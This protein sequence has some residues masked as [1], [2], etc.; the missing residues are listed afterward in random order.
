[1][2]SILDI[3]PSSLMD[4][5]AAQRM[6]IQ[7]TL[8]LRQSMLD[9]FGNYP[10]SNVRPFIYALERSNAQSNALT[11]NSQVEDG[12]I[13]V[14]SDAS[15][16]ACYVTGSSTGDYLIGARYDTGDANI[17]NRAVHSSTFVGTAER[18]MKLPKPM[19]LGGN[20]TITFTLTD[21][22]GAVNEI[23]LSLIGYKVYRS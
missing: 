7:A 19:L 10:S 13:K 22:S 12:S 11:A 1:M 18:P 4:L 23:Y 20:S 8:G 21:L 6:Q 3:D 14:S 16:V 17:S 9:C 15:F 2:P 5:P